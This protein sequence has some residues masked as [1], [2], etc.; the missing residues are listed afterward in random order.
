MNDITQFE[1][2]EVLKGFKSKVKS[3][4]QISTI[5]LK[6]IGFPVSESLRTFFTSLLK[7]TK[8]PTVWFESVLFVI[9][10]GEGSKTKPDNHRTI[11]VQKCDSQAFPSRN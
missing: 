7:C 4:K 1:V 2:M 9:C 5:D 3:T 11:C 8:F 6:K 10:K